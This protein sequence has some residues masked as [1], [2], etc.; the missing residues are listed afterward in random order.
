LLGPEKILHSGQKLTSFGTVDVAAPIVVDGGHLNLS[1]L[2]NSSTLEI[3][4][5]I[6]EGTAILVNYGFIQLNGPLAE[7]RGS[8][9]HNEHT[10]RGS[11]LI[12]GELSNTSTGQVQLI[13]GERLRLGGGSNSNF[14]HISVLGG[15]LQVDGSL[16]NGA[17]TGLISARDAI[18]RFDQVTNNGSMAFSNG[19]VDVYGDITQAV[20]GRI[21]VSNGGIANFYDDVNVLV[22]AANVQATA[23]GST[24]SRVV[25]FGSYNGG[26]S[27][28]GQ[29]FIEGDHRPG[30]S[31]A[32]VEF[33]GDVFYG[34]FA[35]L[36][37]ELGGDIK[38]T[39]YDSVAAAGSVSLGGT[40]DVSLLD[41][42][43]PALGDS[44]EILSAAGGVSGVFDSMLFPD[45]GPQL[46]MD[47]I[48]GANSVTLAVVPALPGDYNNDGTVDA[49]DYVVFRKFEGTTNML[50]NDAIGGTIGPAHYGQWSAHFGQTA[51]S[52]S[53]VSA[54][55][56]VPEPT[57]ALLLI[58]GASF[59]ICKERRVNSRVSI[60]R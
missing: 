6:V 57:G 45:L 30:A 3:H 35:N 33:G 22:G 60:M 10:I 38:G 43:S 2:T 1:T 21:T 18:L 13:A 8:L 53:T 24:V 47:V 7:L 12:N 44:F 41:A 54:H 58:I 59:A 31:P 34:P 9:I 42:F 11:G 14:G 48:Y 56:A 15:E 25:F 37:I 49:A 27:G 29:A 4:R 23:L 52:G 16:S 28:G 20:G 17:S 40:L 19:T 50:P 39:S 51:G 32:L 5:G 26:V 36:E 55:G 46:A